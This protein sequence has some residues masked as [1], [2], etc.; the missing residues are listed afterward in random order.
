MTH[1]HIMNKPKSTNKQKNCS[2]NNILM[3]IC[4]SIACN[5]SLYLSNT[6]IFIF[7]LTVAWTMYQ[8]KRHAILSLLLLLLVLCKG[9]DL[10]FLSISND[11]LCELVDFPLI[12]IQIFAQ[13]H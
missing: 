5:L 4:I 11:D 10:N 3:K 6:L 13:F 1:A 9:L 8:R 2:L 7:S 12:P